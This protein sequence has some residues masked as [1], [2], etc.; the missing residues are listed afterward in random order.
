MHLGEQIRLARVIRGY[1][2]ENLAK[3]FGKSQNWVHN[4][5]T[6]KTEVTAEILEET[7]QF[8]GISIEDLLKLGNTFTFNECINSGNNNTYNIHNDLAEIKVLLETIVSTIKNNNK[9]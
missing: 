8:L 1:S 2:Q 4:I 7:S 6:G 9:L 5:E 3:H